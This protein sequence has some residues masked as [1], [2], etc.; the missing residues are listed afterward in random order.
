M[1]GGA[2]EQNPSRGEKEPARTESQQGPKQQPQPARRPTN[3]RRDHP[4][5][6]ERHSEAA[7]QRE[8]AN[9][10]LC[11]PGLQTQGSASV[12][13]SPEIPRL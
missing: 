2:P 12:Y 7:P 4:R 11:S 9:E 6:G 5:R 1:E 10:R 3:P 8:G 13:G